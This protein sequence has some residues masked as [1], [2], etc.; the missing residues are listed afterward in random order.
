MPSNDPS[1]CPTITIDEKRGSARNCFTQ[2][3]ASSAYMGNRR[4]AS[5]LPALTLP[6]TPRLS[7]RTDAMPFAASSSAGSVGLHGD[8]ESRLGQP[9]LNAAGHTALTAPPGRAAVRSGPLGE[10]IQAVD[11]R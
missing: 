9:R 8:A 2:A 7:H 1:L 4:S 5:D 6:A 10:Q 3:A 11:L